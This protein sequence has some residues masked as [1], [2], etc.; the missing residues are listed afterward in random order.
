[1]KQSTAALLILLLLLVHTS[2]N[3]GTLID[4]SW[5]PTNCGEKPEPPV[6][7]TS[8]SENF[9]R[10]VDAIN[11]WQDRAVEYHAC[12][13][14]EANA[15]NDLIANTANEAQARFQ[16]EINRINAEATQG[17]DELEN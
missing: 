11:E 14:D 7:D 4:G 16:K 12:M 8:S 17:R 13:V 9:N 2:G 10:S 3:A 6:I 15:D 5:V 1:M